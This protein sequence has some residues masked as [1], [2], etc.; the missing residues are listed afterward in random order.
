MQ[1]NKL[2]RAF[3]YTKE[4]GNL[5]TERYGIKISRSLHITGAAMAGGIFIAIGKLVMGILSLSLFACVN[6]FYSFGM[7]GARGIALAGI[8]K[9]G[10][11]KEQYHYYLWSGIVLIVSSLLYILYSIRLFSSPITNF[12]HMNAAIGIATVTFLEMGLNIRGVII[13]RQNHTL[14]VHAI[15]MINLS[16]SLISMVLTQTA[17]LSFTL[18]GT[19]LQKISKANGTIGILMGLA[20]TGIGL[21]MIFRVKKLKKQQRGKEAEYDSYTSGGG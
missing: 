18:Q 16:A 4:T 17:L 2:K 11:S 21:Y 10:A 12:Y 14:L 6:A 5:F 1:N 9:A 20:A 8:K 19:D 15:K 3:Q 13:T 7:A